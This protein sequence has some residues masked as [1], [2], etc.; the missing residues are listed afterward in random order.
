MK[1]DAILDYLGFPASIVAHTR[2]TFSF[3]VLVALLQW[4]NFK[5]QAQEREELP[6]VH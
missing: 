1:F 3:F 2:L 6:E 5:G 4:L